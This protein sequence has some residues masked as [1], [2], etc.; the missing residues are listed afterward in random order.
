VKA[1][2]K[3]YQTI[4]SGLFDGRY[5]PGS[6][7]TE[8]EI[9]AE[10]G[11]SRTPVREA[12][13]RL[14]AE[15]LLHFAPNQGV[16]VASWT[17]SEIEDIFEL[18]SMLESY[19]TERAAAMASDEDLA[20]LRHL[21]EAQLE[22]AKERRPGYLEE[23]SELNSQ[24]HQALQTA[25]RSERLKQMLS[26]L[27]EVPLVAQT[28][29]DY[30]NEELVRSSQ[31]HLEIVQALEARD[32]TGAGSIMRAHVLA[33]RRVFRTS[34]QHRRVDGERRAEALVAATPPA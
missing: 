20:E 25:A 7:I 10:A 24:F 2:E 17:E 32:A 8:Q 4:R 1:A 23:V 14:Q 6:R 21:A 9:A 18:R 22:A 34:E 12:L 29:R 27:V 5:P 26:S 16:V 3:A 33:A 19:A 11:V 13:R 28:F 31:H 15:G 30:S